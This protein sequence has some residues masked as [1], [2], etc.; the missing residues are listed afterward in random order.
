M[1]AQL[2]ILLLPMLWS[3][4]HE[5]RLRNILW[6]DAKFKEACE[7]YGELVTF[8]TTQL[9]NKYKKSFTPFVGVN[10]HE[11]S[12][13]HGCALLPDEMT[14]SF[15][16]LFQT[17]AW[18]KIIYWSEQNYIYYRIYVSKCSSQAT[19]VASTQKNLDMFAE[20]IRISQRRL[21]NTFISLTIDEF[22]ERCEKLMKR[23]YLKNDERLENLDNLISIRKFLCS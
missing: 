6:I 4:E 19:F 2:K 9:T 15:I 21:T 5:W 11:K 12:I 3:L 20:L 18:S 1:H 7:H 22:E 8:D 10:H 14:S 23:F 13:L 17:W 16:W